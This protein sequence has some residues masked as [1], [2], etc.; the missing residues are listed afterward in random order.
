MELN[1]KFAYYQ[2][3]HRLTISQIAELRE[4]S[5]IAVPQIRDLPR[6]L[7]TMAK[8]AELIRLSRLFKAN[9]IDFI[10]IKG[11]LLSWRLHR[12]FTIR[13]SNDLD[14]LVNRTDLDLCFELL[15]SY[16]YCFDTSAPAAGDFPTT[17]NKKKLVMDLKHH[18]V[19]IHRKTKLQLEVHW[20]LFSYPIINQKKFDQLIKE[21]TVP[22]TF[23]TEQFTIFSKEMDF[24]YLMIHG[25]LH[26][27]Y[28]LKWLHDI[29]A[30]SMDPEIS[31]QKV[32]EISK[33]FSAGHLLYQTL[34]LAD[35]FWPVPERIRNIAD[36]N[37][38]SLPP[39]LLSYPVKTISD[40]NFHPEIAH[41]STK[42]IFELTKYTL[43]LF[44]KAIFKSRFIKGLLF[45][46]GDLKILNLPDRFA[47]MY[48]FLRPV[49][50]IYRKC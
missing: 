24:V 39:F 12:D 36:Q 32:K 23:Q 4:F 13:Y 18:K 45:N 27:W 5:G 41:W 9:N 11:P 19:F 7:D 22:F 42:E 31:W 17:K 6:K 43:M 35:I 21:Q 30:Y 8:M 10:S 50:L 1:E 48:F 25:A 38:K 15:K 44:P 37:R 47:F 46:E 14:I 40:R 34:H 29:Y 28:R 33:Y 20:N 49:L 26:H 3:R 2:H 16:E